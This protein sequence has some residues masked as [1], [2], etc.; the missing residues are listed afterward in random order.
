MAKAALGETLYFA[1]TVIGVGQH[2]AVVIDMDCWTVGS[3]RP[4]A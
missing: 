1:P 2:G 4:N 3:L